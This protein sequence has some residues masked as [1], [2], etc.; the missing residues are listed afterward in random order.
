MIDTHGN[1]VTVA[2]PGPAASL[3]MEDTNGNFVSGTGRT[4]SYQSFQPWGD[5]FAKTGS[6]TFAG[7]ATYKYTWGTAT[8]SFSPASVDES[9][10]QYGYD[11]LCTAPKNNGNYVTNPVVVQMQEPDYLYYTFSY[12]SYYGLLN[13]ITYPTGAWVQYTWNVNP[14]SDATGWTTP[15][16]F[17]NYQNDPVHVA[18]GQTMNSS[19][20]FEHDTPAI[21]KRVV[22]YDG[23]IP[24]LEQDY[25]YSTDWGSG[26][27]F[28]TWKSKQTVVTTKDLLSNGTP[29]FQTI[30]NYLPWV[31]YQS[32]GS[33]LAP[34]PVAVENTIVYKDTAGNVLRT[35]TKAWNYSNQLAGECRTLPNGKTSGIFYKY[36]PYPQQGMNTVRGNLE[37]GTTDILTDVAEYDYGQ[38]TSPC[39]RPTTTAARETITKLCEFSQHAFVADVLHDER[40]EDGAYI[41]AANGR[42]SRD[43]HQVS[44]WHEDF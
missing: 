35:V 38:V 26:G 13:K 34:T 27:I 41:V 20:M 10:I 24:A 30:Y 25:S 31:S 8:S 5:A 7:G 43:D 18:A 23:N 33:H 40:H 22:S 1:A 11:Y 28:G 17:T 29:S 14:L 37:S 39:T 16:Q 2:I 44:E 15:S 19:C 3:T 36:E 32:L 9:V 12:D 42:S 4:G 6:R 21:K